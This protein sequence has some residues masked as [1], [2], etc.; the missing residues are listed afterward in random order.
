MEQDTGEVK[1]AFQKKD[2]KP[3]PKSYRIETIADITKCVTSENIDGFLRDFE[4]VLRSYLLMKELNNAGIKE[5]TI[6]EGAEIEMP[7]F[8]WI[9]D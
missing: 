2:P 9:D 7:F 4:M 3:D 5:G 6:P 8:E 1:I